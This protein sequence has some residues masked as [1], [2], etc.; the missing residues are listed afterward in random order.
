MKPSIASGPRSFF[1]HPGLSRSSLT[2]SSFSLSGQ[3]IPFPRV[4]RSAR[5]LTGT[6]ELGWE[7]MTFA[8][9]GASA[10]ASVALAFFS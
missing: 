9:L 3:I 10:A 6:L 4:D 5:R 1:L 8:A 7:D 2:N